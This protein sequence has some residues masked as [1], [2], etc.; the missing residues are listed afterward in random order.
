MESPKPTAYLETS[1]ISYLTGRDSGDLIVAAHQ[2]DY[3]LTWNFKH[4]ANAEKWTQI[5]EICASFQVKM[6]VICSPL[7]LMD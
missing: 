5:R 3:L 1:Y 2:I 6:P 4:I 7:E